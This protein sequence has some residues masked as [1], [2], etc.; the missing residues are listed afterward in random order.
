[1]AFLPRDLVITL[2]LWVQKKRHYGVRMDAI[3]AHHVNSD[4]TSR[5]KDVVGR[6]LAAPN[7]HAP[8]ILTILNPVWDESSCFIMLT[9]SWCRS[10][11]E[12]AAKRRIGYARRKGNI[13]YK[14]EQTGVHT[15]VVV[16]P[17]RGL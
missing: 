13:I 10:I 16:V 2:R 4:A 3:R 1:V 17:R 14:Y 11:K 9:K 8:S 12:V 5:P 7:C 15:V 6:W